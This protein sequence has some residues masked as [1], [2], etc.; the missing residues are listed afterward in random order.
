ME[1]RETTV[2]AVTCTLKMAHYCLRHIVSFKHRWSHLQ[3]HIY[4]FSTEMKQADWMWCD[5]MRLTQQAQWGRFN[6]AMVSFPSL[7]KRSRRGWSQPSISPQCAKRRPLC[8]V[9]RKSQQEG[10][11]TGNPGYSYTSFM[12]SSNGIWMHGVTCCYMFYVLCS[13]ELIIKIYSYFSKYN[14]IQYK[15]YNTIITLHVIL[16]LVK[17]ISNWYVAF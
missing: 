8:S 14:M 1:Y 4:H 9:M 16:A 17:G 15:Q 12:F 11:M 13:I 2:T 6:T 10:E 5:C 7:W 3:S